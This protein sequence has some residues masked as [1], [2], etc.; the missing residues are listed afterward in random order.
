M[1]FVRDKAKMRDTQKAVIFYFTVQIL[2]ATVI[3]FSLINNHY[4]LFFVA[5]IV[6]LLCHANA[7]D[8][9]SPFNDNRK[10]SLGPLY[11][12]KTRNFVD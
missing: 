1:D 9:V 4:L 12:I 5:L 10:I 2:L 8:D 11:R 6:S 3:T 7:V